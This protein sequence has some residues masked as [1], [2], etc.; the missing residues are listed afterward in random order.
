MRAVLPV[1][2]ML[3]RPN[4]QGMAWMILSGAIFGV[5]N[6]IL[7]IITLQLPPIEAQFL[8]YVSGAVVMLPFI[9][10]IGLRAFRPN[11]LAGQLWRGAAHT[12]GMLLWFIALPHLPL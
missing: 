6:A 1:P 7:R 4:V 10:R 3:L 2:A 9:L 8:R 12:S 11:G 5:L